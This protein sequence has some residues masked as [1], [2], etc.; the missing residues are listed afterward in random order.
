MEDAQLVAERK[1]LQLKGRTAA[2]GQRK[3]AINA[4]STSTGANRR[5]RDD[6]QSITQIRSEFAGATGANSGRACGRP[7]RHS[8]SRW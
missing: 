3:D 4:E 7:P 2:E 5:K 6:S 1:D 8:V